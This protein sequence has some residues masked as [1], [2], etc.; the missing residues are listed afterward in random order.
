MQSEIPEEK[1]ETPLKKRPIFDNWGEWMNY[2]E[3]QYSIKDLQR[4]PN[5]NLYTII[6]DNEKKRKINYGINGK[7]NNI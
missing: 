6:I 1:V 7:R 4:F 2:Q 3:T 5:I